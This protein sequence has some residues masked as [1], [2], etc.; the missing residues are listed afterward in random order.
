M[1]TSSVRGVLT[2][3]GVLALAAAATTVTMMAGA[4]TPMAS[5]SAV[6]HRPPRAAAPAAGLSGVALRR[7]PAGLPA[8]RTFPTKGG[9]LFGGNDGLSGLATQLGRPMA[10]VRTYYKLG[11]NA[12]PTYNDN[13]HM[14]AGT[15]L[16]VSLD[17][18]G[19]SYASIIAG[20]YDTQILAFMTAMNADAIKYNLSSIFFTFQHEPDNKL[21]ASLGTA[22]QFVEAWDHVHALAAANDLDW[23]QSDGGRLLWTLILVHNTYAMGTNAKG[24]WPGPG[25]VD[26]VASDGYNVDGCTAK[27]A[28]TPSEIFGATLSFAKAN[29]R[30]PVF[31]AEWASYAG[32]P[33]DQAAYIAAMQTY[34]TTN[35]KKI[36]AAMYWDDAGPLCSFKIDGNAGSIAAMKT[37]GASADMQGTAHT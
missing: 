6:A 3:R 16:L 33:T 18:N 32:K 34:L 1:Q 23:N 31:L 28:Q 12:F 36:K 17:A 15:T 13:K 10:I 7:D 37:L 30:L 26:I 8:V 11:G 19:H 5:A 4:S 29:G 35:H 21:V 14:A 27:P 24:Y 2:R 25:E 20:D 22:A 9:M